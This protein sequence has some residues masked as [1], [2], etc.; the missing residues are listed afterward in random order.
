MASRPVTVYETMGP[1]PVY[2]KPPAIEE[3][4]ASIKGEYGEGVPYQNPAP[5]DYFK[6]VIVPPPPPLRGILGPTTREPQ[7]IAQSAWKPSPADYNCQRPF[8][9][10]QKGTTSFGGRKMRDYLPDTDGPIPPPCSTLG[11][12]RFTIKAS[13]YG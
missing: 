10:E 1:G 13:L 4:A 7:E 11:G 6:A 5:T 8:V 2:D 12:P 3:R 9:E